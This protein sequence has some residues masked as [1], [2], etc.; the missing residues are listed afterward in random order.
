MSCDVCFVSPVLFHY[1]VSIMPKFKYIAKDGHQNV[2][3]TI[4][5]HSKEDAIEK[6]N[7]RGYLPVR[8]EI[9]TDSAKNEVPH[10]G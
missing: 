5:A 6:I 10:G 9:Q 2:D 4:E 8:V 3:G 1:A 7:A